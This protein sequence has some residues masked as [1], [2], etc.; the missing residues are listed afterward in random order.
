[1]LPERI[2]DE[3]GL[4]GARWRDDEQATRL[5]LSPV[6]STGPA[7][8]QQEVELLLEFAIGGV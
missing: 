7:L 2:P 5:R 4:A 6:L 8:S 3:R 1:M